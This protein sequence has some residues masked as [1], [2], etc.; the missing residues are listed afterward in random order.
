MR[1]QDNCEPKEPSWPEMRE[2]EREGEMGPGLFES[3]LTN[4]HW[5]EAPEAEMDGHLL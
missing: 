2:T 3:G 4:S 1:G 5:D